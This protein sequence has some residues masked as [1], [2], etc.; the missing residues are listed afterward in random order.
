MSAWGVCRRLDGWLWGGQREKD[1]MLKG[2]GEGEDGEG[3]LGLERLALWPEAALDMSSAVFC[4]L[5]AWRICLV[6]VVRFG[7]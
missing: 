3:V 1:S 7:I 5:V 6:V 4:I 2:E